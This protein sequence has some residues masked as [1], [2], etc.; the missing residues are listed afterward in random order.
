MP[1]H[2]HPLHQPRSQVVGI[3]DGPAAVTE[4]ITS[5]VHIVV[6][7]AFGPVGRHVICAALRAGETSAST[8]SPG[9]LLGRQ[10]AWVLMGHNPGE[11]WKRGTADKHDCSNDEL[12]SAVQ[13]YLAVDRDGSAAAHLIDPTGV[14]P[15]VWRDKYRARSGDVGITVEGV[16]AY[17]AIWT[18]AYA[19][20]DLLYTQGVDVT[21]LTESKVGRTQ[22]FDTLVK[23]DFYGASGRVYF[24]PV[25]GDR[26]GLPVKVRGDRWKESYYSWHTRARVLCVLYDVVISNE[27]QHKWVGTYTYFT[28]E[29]AG[30]PGTCGGRRWDLRTV[31]GEERSRPFHLSAVCNKGCRVRTRCIR[32]VVI[33]AMY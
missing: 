9:P 24:D 30:V 17:D 12:R 20:H 22:L 31:H 5:K 33:D 29:R 19:L 2:I 6:L 10:H 21:T 15:K 28:K 25:S 11:W 26:R 23:Q 16:A 13:G 1:A 32:S 18:W 8:S 27:P 14:E 7:L 3:D 4:L